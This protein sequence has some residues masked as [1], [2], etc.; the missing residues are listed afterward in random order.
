V[1]LLM[2]YLSS[3]LLSSPSSSSLSSSPLSSSPAAMPGWDPVAARPSRSR[4]PLLGCPR[5]SL[6]CLSK[7][8]RVLL[9]PQL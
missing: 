7:T 2:V 9:L 8:G 4:W 6:A 3:S 1:A 5:G